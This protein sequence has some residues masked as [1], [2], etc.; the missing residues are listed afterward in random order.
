MSAD[1]DGSV[2]LADRVRAAAEAAMPLRIV[3]GDTKAWY[4]RHVAGEPLNV[5]GHRGILDYQ[6][7][8]LVITAR[9]GTPLGEIETALAERGQHLPFEPLHTGDGA[10]IGGA[11]ASGLAGAARP[12]AGAARDY[13]L[14]V[15][16]L[17]GRGRRLRFGGTVFK[18]V[19]GFD[20]FRLMCGALGTLGVLLDVSLRVAPRPAARVVRKIDVDWVDVAPALIGL[21]AHSPLTGAAHAEGLVRVRLAGP[22]AAVARAARDIGGEDDDPVWWD[23]LRRL[24]IPP[25]TE[26]RLWRLVLPAERPPMLL[27]GRSLIDWANGLIWFSDASSRQNMHESAARVFGHAVLFRGARQSEAVFPPLPAALMAL[28]RRIKAAFD[29]RGI[30]N[31]GRIYPEL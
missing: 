8:E 1:A 26:P 3:G 14:G 12:F 24:E 21:R 28:H 10:T 6:P 9:A 16:V 15:T 2:A 31:P 23:R 18:N 11:I 7:S 17:D 13:L 27:V 30:L 29:P 4:G 22:S 19:A 25:L 20:L 5:A